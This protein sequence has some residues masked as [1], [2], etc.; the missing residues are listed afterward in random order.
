M[1]KYFL[2]DVPS[3]PSEAEVDDKTLI[4]GDEANPTDLTKDQAERL[5]ATG[6]KLERSAG[7]TSGGSD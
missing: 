7:Q 6:V 5:E 3:N 2:K 1:P 4:K